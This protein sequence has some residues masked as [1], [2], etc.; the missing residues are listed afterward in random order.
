MR[1]GLVSWGTEGDLRPFLALG[2]ALRQRGHVVTLVFTGVEG[3]D[4]TSLAERS[5]V[6]TRFVDDGYFVANRAE[7]ARRASEGLALGSPLRQFELILRD[8]MDPVAD[9]MLDAS[10][11][12][13][14][15]SDVVVGHFLAHTAATAAEAHGKP[16]VLLALQPVF[17]S[18]H[19]PPAGAPALG[20]L[21]NRLTWKL[22]DRVMGAALLGRT[23]AGRARCGLPPLSGFRPVDVGNPHAILVAVSPSLFVRP[24][25]WAVGLEVSG[26]LD[27]PES[28]EV[29][30]PEPR[31]GAFL[32]EAPPVFLSFGSMFAMDERQTMQSIETFASALT[33]ARARGIVQAPASVIARAPRQENV[34]YIERAPHAQLFPRCSA[35]VHH[36][37]AGTMQSA[38]LAG[39]GAVV[40]PHAADQF[41][42]GDLLHARGVAAKPLKRPAL[43]AKPLAARIRAVLD[44]DRMATRAGAL[45]K[46]L[47]AENGRERAAETVERAGG[48]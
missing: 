32:D 15:E 39:R 46:A 28:A 21:F 37:G 48:A 44:D 33:L 2:Q 1:V 34:C 29:W 4:F 25:D 40:V 24:P 14:A 47:G 22:A 19:Y 43:A 38:L 45:A 7:I 27:L 11:A 16:F 20:R 30:E 41:Y 17:A 10:R 36:G 3:R 13:A 5:G 35:I 18:A 6:P 42:W 9:A 31:V 26:F 12:L 8:M 23:N